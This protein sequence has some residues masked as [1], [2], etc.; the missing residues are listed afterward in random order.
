MQWIFTP[1]SPWASTV[2][3]CDNDLEMSLPLFLYPRGSGYKKYIRVGYNIISIRI[4]SL[5]VYFTY[6]IYI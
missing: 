4:I 2:V 5:F 6:I 1:V 3:I